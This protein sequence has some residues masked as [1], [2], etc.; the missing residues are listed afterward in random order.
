MK[1]R[2]SEPLRR[3][4]SRGGLREF[5]LLGTMVRPEPLSAGIARPLMRLSRP[6]AVGH[7]DPKPLKAQNI[8]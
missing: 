1:Y 6:F 3:N 2:Q 5:I 7:A 8:L 4:G